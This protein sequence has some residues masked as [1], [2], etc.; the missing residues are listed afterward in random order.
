MTSSQTKMARAFYLGRIADFI[1]SEANAILGSLTKNSGFS[2]EITQ[3]DA[4]RSQITI[5]Q[6]ELGQ[7]ADKGEIYFEFVVPRLGKRLFIGS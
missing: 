5:L 4:W 6:K 2:I 3:R 1:N 7:F